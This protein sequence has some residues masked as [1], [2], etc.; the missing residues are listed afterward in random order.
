MDQILNV[1]IG[2]IETGEKEI[3][4]AITSSE[5]D[6]NGIIFK[7]IESLIESIDLDVEGGETGIV[8]VLYSVAD[9]IGFNGWY[10]HSPNVTIQCDEDSD[11]GFVTNQEKIGILRDY[12]KN[13]ELRN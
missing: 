11:E 8:R 5:K 12:L 7:A 2:N 10:T 9:H 13:I 1:E 3:D 4:I 6:H